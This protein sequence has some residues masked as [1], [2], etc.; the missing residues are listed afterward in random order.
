MENQRL[1]YIRK[2]GRRKGR[3]KGVLFCGID[4]DDSKSVVI[5][6]TLCHAI[7]KFDY[8]SGQRQ[9]GFGRDTAKLRADKWKFHTDYFVQR[10][11]TEDEIIQAE[12][13]GD[14]SIDL[15]VYENPDSITTI[16]IPPSVMVR[17]KSFIERCKKYYKDKDFPLWIEKVLSGDSLPEEG[18]SKC[19]VNHFYF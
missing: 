4:P 14:D 15:M 10:T 16:E 9:D 17:L 11:F 2:N 5:G 7:D 1:E 13:G 3:K 8:I 19:R 12:E 18:L 6:F